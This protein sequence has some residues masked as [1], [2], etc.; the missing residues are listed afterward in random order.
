MNTNG[1][2]RTR[3][4]WGAAL[5]LLVFLAGTG[6]TV[7]Q[8]H[9]DSVLAQRYSRLQTTVYLLLAA[10]E[11]DTTGAIVMP[12]NLAEPR[13][14][15]PRSGLY[16]SIS[17]ADGKST[18]RSDSS[19]NQILASTPSP[20][21]GQWQFDAAST[22]TASNPEL[23]APPVFLSA[24]YAVMWSV[25]A[26]QTPLLFTVLEDKAQFD[27]E[28]KTFGRTLW[29]WLATTGVLL[30]LTQT[31]L[32]RWALKPLGHLS[33]EIERIE[34]GQQTQLVGRYPKELA[35]LTRNLNLLIDQE[36]TRQTRYRQALDDLAHSL[37]TPLAAL[38][39]TL[40]DPDA[41]QARVAEQ[42]RRMDDIVVH[43][44]GRAGAG[45]RVL[46]A[47]KLTMAPVLQRI[48]DTLIKVYADKQLSWS[49]TCAD[50]LAWRM[51]EG[52]AF[53][54]LGNLMDNAAKWA[55]QRAAVQIWLDDAQRLCI[56]V[57][58]DGPGFVDPQIVGQ[59]RVRLD[60]QTPGHGIGLAVVKDLVHSHG[61]TLGVCKSD[62][63][64]AQVDI[65][66][67]DKASS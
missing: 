20:A 38:R 23:T 35:G 28:V 58:D 55:R 63:G 43:Q 8:A 40:D 30:L 45:G 36:R 14:S 56:R 5:V 1:S 21:L 41:L 16:A 34:Q 46:F 52:D 17:R 66:L 22:D 62:L 49:L 54:M 50:A 18:W 7:Q 25:G 3:L 67:P 29:S 24:T 26:Q 31:L 47:P 57:T 4:A 12:T 33:R 48:H 61:G 53:E 59:R 44:L 15:L 10:A 9:A 39:A 37:K 64:G 2:I 6:W 51:S 42:V 65:T 19:L 13:L 27:R 32:L 11:L 60:E